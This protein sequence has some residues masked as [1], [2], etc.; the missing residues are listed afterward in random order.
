[1]AAVE[2]LAA[3]EECAVHGGGGVDAQGVALAAPYGHPVVERGPLGGLQVGRAEEVGDLA[4]HVEGDRSQTI[5]SR[6]PSEV[7]RAPTLRGWPTLVSGGW[8][9]SARLAERFMQRA[10][11]LG[12]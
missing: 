2:G 4:E 1:M 5:V 3:G 6:H 12:N 8:R 11:V 7:W 9:R 10:I